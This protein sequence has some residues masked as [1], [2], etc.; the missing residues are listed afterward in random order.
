MFKLIHQGH[1]FSPED[2][3]IKDVLICGDKIVRIENNLYRFG[4]QLDAEVI[5]ARAAL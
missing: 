3:G 4:K 2:K 1:L 5:P